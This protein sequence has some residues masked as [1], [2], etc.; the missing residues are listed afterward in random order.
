MKVTPEL[1]KFMETYRDDPVGFVRDV[2]GAEPDPP[3]AAVLR[4]IAAGERR[5][6]VRSG[7]GVGKST[8]AAWAVVW[9]QCTRFPVKIVITAPTSAQ[10]FDALYAE[11]KAWYNKLPVGL[12]ELFDVK[13]E[14][15]EFVAAPAES[16]VSVRTSRAE[17]PE[18]M[19]G[20]HSKN[21]LLIG[22]EASGIP[23]QVFEAAAGSMSGHEATTLLLGNPV[24]STGF[25][26]DTHTRLEGWKRHHISCETS[27]RVSKDFISD[28]KDRYGE[29][30]NAYRVRVLGEFPVADD[31]TVI[32]LDHI[33]SAAAREVL[34]AGTT[35]EVWAL[36]VARFGSDSSV[37]VKRK[38][39]FVRE[40][41]VW[42]NIDLM[43]LSH[44]VALEYESLPDNKRPSMILVDSIGVGAGVVDRLTELKIPVIGVN[45]SE[46]PAFGKKFKNLR[47]ELWW[48]AKDW[49]ASLNGQIPNNDGL[50]YE[51]AMVKY[52]F[53]PSGRLVIES[54]DEIKK[55]NKGRSPDMADAFVMTFAERGATMLNGWHP[56]GDSRKPLRRD[57]K[58]VI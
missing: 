13:S 11:V 10:L 7:H 33:Q 52:K 40:P 2:F 49:F 23:E 29:E 17:Q 43:R 42:R 4:D 12:Q 1:L 39:N 55:R 26:F 3:Q 18:A 46:A 28:M 22:D 5:I 51:L 38:G 27:P 41:K 47:A 31:N 45:V 30:S 16:F 15:I 25:F 21:V 19:Q 56:A 50:I 36:D 14:R 54:K 20:V 37:L 57:L 53:D 8:T 9:F 32:P 24:R 48:A 58:T 35:P 6:T 34:P 44:E